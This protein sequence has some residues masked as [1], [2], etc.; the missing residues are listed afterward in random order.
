MTN[1][2]RRG[3][4]SPIT[5]GPIF[6]RLRSMGIA[7]PLD[8]SIRRT[9][10]VAAAALAIS[11]LAGLAFVDQAGGSNTRRVG[12]PTTQSTHGTSTST[13]W[14]DFLEQTSTTGRRSRTTSSLVG[15]KETARGAGPS[16]S[17]APSDAPAAK[18]TAQFDIAIPAA[19]A[20]FSAGEGDGS[21]T[22]AQVTALTP[23]GCPAPS[24]DGPVIVRYQLPGS[25]SNS[26]LG[27]KR[28]A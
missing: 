16:T 21:C 19:G 1:A 15:G 20:Q 12:S 14:F 10:L 25:G 17:V 8:R 5:A 22:T 4:F 26:L 7:P 13:T 9:A 18:P 2:A 3:S 28:F 27:K 11:G 23:D 6:P 24:G